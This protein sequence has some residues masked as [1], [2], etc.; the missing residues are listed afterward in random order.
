MV[1]SPPVVVLTRQCSIWKPGGVSRA[2]RSVWGGSGSGVLAVEVGLRST[3]TGQVTPKLVSRSAPMRSPSAT[4]E[5]AFGRQV[6]ESGEPV[7]HG[8]VQ[9][10]QQDAVVVQH[11]RTVVGRRSRKFGGGPLLDLRQE[12]I[13]TMLLLC[14]M[15]E[16]T[17]VV[18]RGGAVGPLGDDITAGRDGHVAQHVVGGKISRV[19]LRLSTAFLDGDI[20]HL[21][22]EKPECVG[23]EFKTVGPAETGDGPQQLSGSR[24]LDRDRRRSRGSAL[25][26]Y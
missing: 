9:E 20:A 19:E 4:S 12:G 1:L 24:R 6:L 10:R 25:L 8:V 26:S 14:D 3:L 7:A 23:V 13:G 15:T 22:F 11:R 16:P 21:V 18:D 5:A 2:G 17:A